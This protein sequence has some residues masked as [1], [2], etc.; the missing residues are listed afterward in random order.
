LGDLAGPGIIRHLWTTTV[1][2]EVGYP[3]LLVL[4]AYWDGEEHPSVE[5]PLGDFFAV[6]HGLDRP[7]S[8]A[9]VSVSSHGRAR[10]CYWPMPFAKSARVTLTNE[11]REPVHGLFWYLDW[12]ATPGLGRD[13]GYFHAQYRQEHPA[14]M[15]RNYLIADIQGRGHYV[16]TVLNVRQRQPGWWGEGDDFFFIDGETEPSLRGTGSEDYFCDAWGLRPFAYPYYGVTVFEQPHALGLTT[17]YRW[18]LPDPVRFERSLR[19]EIE[20]KGVTFDAEGRLTSHFGE[21][22]DDLSSVAFW[23]QT[24]PHAPF[25]PLAAAYARVTHDPADVI[26]VE[27]LGPAV[28]AS[29]GEPT[30]QHGPWSGGAQL[31]WVGAQGEALRATFSTPVAGRYDLVLVLTLS[32]DYGVFD[33][34]LDDAPLARA[35]DL[36]QETFSSREFRFDDLFL[37]AGTHTLAFVTVGQAARSKGHLLGIDCLIVSAARTALAQ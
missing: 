8:S 15:G 1:Q 25:P 9:P 16:G 33:V 27:K 36:Y 19:V 22:D 32:W 28:V 18:H 37:N 6:G 20:H 21:R 4:R 13:L 7:F 31:L 35:L 14:Q 24:E 5:C 34:L 12:E 2:S 17:A 29:A 30:T 3:R 26:E 11:G 23:Y 10:N